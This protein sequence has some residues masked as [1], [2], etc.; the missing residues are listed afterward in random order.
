MNLHMHKTYI[1]GRI[2]YIVNTVDTQ[3]EGAIETYHGELQNNVGNT[4]YTYPGDL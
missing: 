1:H 2:E 4:I 3:Y